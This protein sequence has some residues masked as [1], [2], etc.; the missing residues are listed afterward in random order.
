MAT[1]VMPSKTAPTP[2]YGGCIAKYQDRKNDDEGGVLNPA[3]AI[4]DAFQRG[5]LTIACYLMSVRLGKTDYR[6]MPTRDGHA[7]ATRLTAIA[8]A[9]K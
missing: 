4:A 8:E 9:A 7:Q 2:L 6:G 3:W 1:H 5:K